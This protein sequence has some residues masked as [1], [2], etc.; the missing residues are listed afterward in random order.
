ME[1]PAIYYVAPV[2]LSITAQVTPMHM[3]KDVVC[4][5][6]NSAIDA[7]SNSAAGLLFRLFYFRFLLLFLHYDAFS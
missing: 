3:I 2:N 7:L 5:D 6:E 4:Y 1:R